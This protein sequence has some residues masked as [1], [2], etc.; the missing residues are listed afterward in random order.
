MHHPAYWLEGDEPDDIVLSTRIR[1]A[2][3]LHA[4]PFP[5]QADLEQRISVRVLMEP[6]LR[7]LLGRGRVYHAE[8][9]P[10]VLLQYLFERNLISSHYLEP[11]VGG[12]IAL[13]PQGRISLMV[14]EEDHLRLQLLYPGL[15]LHQ[16]LDEASEID[17]KLGRELDFAW[18]REFGYLT[19][20]WTNLGTGL[21]ASV[22]LHLPA[23]NWFGELEYQVEGYRD[24]G[25]EFRGL[26]GEGSRSLASFIQ[27][28]NRDTLGKSATELAGRVRFYAIEFMGLEREA[29]AVI[30][31]RYQGQLQ[32]RVDGALESL[33]SGAP[34]TSARSSQLLSL[35]HLGACL[36]MLP[37]FHPHQIIRLLV[38]LRPAHLQ[39]SEGFELKEEQRDALRG[40]RLKEWLASLQRFQ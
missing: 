10:A 21:R 5:G 18:D 3:N 22:M 34:L 13:C 40:R 35:L 8:K 4:Y 17:R 19:R 25:L 36:E 2:R 38:A 30:K 31:T 6:L 9:P 1:L 24:R 37:S 12:L 11:A 26:F 7:Q 33:A 32:E 15:A 27:L 28:S 16:A 39:L 29:R 23:L 14:N 20:C